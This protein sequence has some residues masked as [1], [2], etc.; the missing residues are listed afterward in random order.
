MIESSRGSGHP[1][2]VTLSDCAV[3]YIDR[4]WPVI[5]LWPVVEN[6]GIELPPLL[7]AMGYRRAPT[8]CTC[9]EG[10]ACAATGKHPALSAWS[11]RPFI[12][13]DAA[14]RK[15]AERPWGIGVELGGAGLVVID[16]DAP[17][18]VAWWETTRW[19]AVDTL[20]VS[21]SPGRLHVYFQQDP[22]DVLLGRA[23]QAQVFAAHRVSKLE[24]RGNGDFVV[25]PPST[26]WT[27]EPYR[28][29]ASNR[30][31][32]MLPEDLRAWI[33][34]ASGSPRGGRRGSSSGRPTDAGSIRNPEAWLRAA[35]ARMSRSGA[36]SR[37]NDVTAVARALRDVVQA[38]HYDLDDVRV[39]FIDAARSTGVLDDE[40]RKTWDTW[41]RNA[42]DPVS[43]Q[44][45]AALCRSVW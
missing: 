4:G 1:T 22:E 29:L 3:A 18:A 31:V 5:P 16:C 44:E 2:A 42:E 27:G 35:L 13:P 39:R 38:G 14:R 12:D 23:T 11:K 10:G 20:T 6:T 41:C 36:G 26:H 40:L 34:A 33:V 43:F 15:W 21:T 17:S 32:A 25:V 24:I 37:N 30:P 45:F 9:L 7:T 8:Q 28:W 19:A